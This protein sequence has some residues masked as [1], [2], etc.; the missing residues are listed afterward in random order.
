L[1]A[2]AGKSGYNGYMSDTLRR[3]AEFLS[4]ALGRAF[5][6]IAVKGEGS[7][8]YGEDGAKY[9]DLTSGIAVNQLGHAHPEVVQAI[10]EQAA[11]CIHTSC[12][13]HY[14]AN[15][16]LA[17]K[18]SQ[19]TP[20]KIS[21]TF[22]SNSGAEAIDGAMKLIKL[23]Q[24]GRNNVIVHKGA[25]HGRTLGATS[26]TTSKS[27]YRRYYEPLLN[28]VYAVDFP[29]IYASGTKKS[30]EFLLE[31]IEDIF[32][33]Q[34]DTLVHPETVS[35]IIIEPVQG[36][37]GYIPAPGLSGTKSYLKFLREFCDKH[38]ILLV[39][40]EV[41]CGMGRT[42]KWFASEHYGVEPDIIVMAKGL[43]GGLPL[44]AFSTRKELMHKMPPGSHGSTFGGNPISCRAAL[45][46]IEI[47][48]RD[49]VMENVSK[50]SEQI[51]KF[52]ETKF[53]GS[54]TRV[55]V[56]EASAKTNEPKSGHGF[57]AYHNAK[58]Q[59]RG[60][61]L[62]VALVFPDSD[63]A[64]K[65]KKH[66]YENNILIL[67]CGTYGNIIRLAPDLIISEENLAHGLE[68]IAEAII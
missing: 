28:G 67:G 21:S 65:I 4:P 46:L 11:K 39:F 53:P 31:H 20:G 57:S 41:Q 54:D 12:V 37:G 50:R 61:G 33:R 56:E 44:G 19:I 52:F 23:L 1:I 34:F 2:Y 47:L 22:F 35:A 66:A 26:L 60:L 43:S 15:I 24:P 63:T 25:F 9:L 5:D 29:N 3:D 17:E 48:E 62:M 30:R 64:T 16:D 49:N 13:V 58:V 55:A 18:L 59:V 27:S 68:K 51:F 36:E 10:A 38:G 8:L 45:K 7:F 40:D 42:G 6:L 32:I 14:P